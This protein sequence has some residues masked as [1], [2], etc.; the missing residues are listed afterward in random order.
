MSATDPTPPDWER[1]ASRLDRHAILALIPDEAA[2]CRRIVAEAP[3]D[4]LRAHPGAAL[5][6]EVFGRLAPGTQ[7]V[8]VPQQPDAVQ[9]VVA[10]GSARRILEHLLLSAV[11]HRRHGQVMAAGRLARSAMPLLGSAQDSVAAGIAPLWYSEAGLIALLAGDWETAR[12]WLLAARRLRDA[13]EVP[14]VERDVLARLAL[15]T[16]WS[17]L[18]EEARSWVAAF[19]ASDAP[20]SAATE[21]VM[22]TARLALA[23][24]VCDFAEA[25]RWSALLADPDR[26]DELWTFSVWARTRALLMSHRGETAQRLVED[27]AGFHA[28]RLARSDGIDAEMVAVLRVEC[29]AILGQGARAAALAET[30]RPTGP[31]GSWAAWNLA[32]IRH[33][34][35]GDFEGADALAKQALATATLPRFVRLLLIRQGSCAAACGRDEEAVAALTRAVRRTD[36]NEGARAWGT[37]TRSV[38][39]PLAD[40]VPGMAQ[41]LERTYDHTGFGVEF[42]RLTQ[43]ERV[44]LARLAEGLDQRAIAATLVVS[45]NTVRSQLRTLYAKLGVSSRADALARAGDLG[46]LDPRSRG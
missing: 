6:A 21:R 1:A 30:I 42:V 31:L 44:V 22:T 2:E 19:D 11:A 29:F 12:S 13:N 4:V 45:V 5:A 15:L 26:D 32:G 20:T 16:V 43:R 3:A 24:E 17:G 7:A 33:Q 35:A 28:R 25:T 9:R 8:R 39:A 40:R 46:L 34:L 23:I 41:L 38:V 36:P 37:A 14:S 10:D 27:A 18:A